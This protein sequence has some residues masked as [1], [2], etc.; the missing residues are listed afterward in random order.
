MGKKHTE[1]QRQA[2]GSTAREETSNQEVQ[3]GTDKEVDHKDRESVW[4]LA[5]SC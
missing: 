3:E 1:G 4:D 5:Q 2:E